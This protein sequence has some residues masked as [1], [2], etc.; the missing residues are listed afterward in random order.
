MQEVSL[1]HVLNLVWLPVIEHID[2]FSEGRPAAWTSTL[3]K[4]QDLLVAE[5]EGA[6]LE[7]A[8]TMPVDE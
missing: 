3:A 6:T 8:T 5:M 1:M 4:H 2:A 7:A